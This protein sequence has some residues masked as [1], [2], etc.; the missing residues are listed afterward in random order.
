M[1]SVGNLQTQ[2]VLAGFEFDFTFGA[3]ITPVV[4]TVLLG[5]GTRTRGDF[6]IIETS[7]VDEDV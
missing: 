4:D 7:T 3:S 1:C 5:L 2:V 6:T